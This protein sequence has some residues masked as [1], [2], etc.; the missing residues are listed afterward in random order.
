M[1]IAQL[2]YAA[3]IKGGNYATPPGEKL[4]LIATSLLG[5]NLCPQNNEFG[6]AESVNE[7]VFAAFGDYAG[8]DLSTARMYLSIQNNAKFVRVDTPIQGDILISPTGYGNGKLANGHTGIVGAN[9]VIMSN[10]SANGLWQENYTLRTW[11]ER[12]VD[13]GGFPMAYFRRV[14]M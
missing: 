9:G 4:Y 2:A 13:L 7:V 6:C 10:N 5:R 14:F 1:N 8:G 11:K 3:L 12:Y